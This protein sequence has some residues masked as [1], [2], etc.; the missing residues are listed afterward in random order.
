MS[1]IFC[2]SA[3]KAYRPARLDH[4]AKFNHFMRWAES[5][6]VAPAS[7]SSLSS[8]AP[9]A[10]Q[11]VR[12]VNYGPQESVR[13]FI[14]L[15]DSS[16]F[17]EVTEDNLLSANFQKLN[18]FKN[19]K[20]EE[21][22]KFFELNLYQEDPINAHHWRANL[23]RPARDID[24]ALR[25]KEVISGF[26]IEEEEEEEESAVTA[27]S[28]NRPSP[29]FG[30]DISVSE[31]RAPPVSGHHMSEVE[32]QVRESLAQLVVSCSAKFSTLK[33]ILKFVL[34]GVGPN[35]GSNPLLSLTSLDWV[36][37]ELDLGLD[38]EDLWES[39]LTS[40]NISIFLNSCIELSSSESV[41]LMEIEDLVDRAIYQMDSLK[42]KQVLGRMRFE[43]IVD[44][45]LESDASVGWISHNGSKIRH[46]L[47]FGPSEE[48]L[49][50]CR[51]RDE[52]MQQHRLHRKDAETITTWFTKE[53]LLDDDSD[54]YGRR[55]DYEHYWGNEPVKDDLA[56]DTGCGYCGQCVG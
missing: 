21:H 4:E 51:H 8:E 14:P 38:Y 7:G 42:D 18:S 54:N 35:L 55:H 19:F 26:D 44:R 1:S 11:L 39:E 33:P 43:S 10:I 40:E 52:E 30:H 5:D 12:Q 24:L 31:S 49:S 22:N 56:C 20:C 15:D 6:P 50:S 37:R 46:I 2:C 17:L 28:Q 29:D 45:V 47:A 53:N 32:S 16:A 3:I 13:Y 23:E 27:P 48:L 34:P 9:Y 25:K 41:R 36:N